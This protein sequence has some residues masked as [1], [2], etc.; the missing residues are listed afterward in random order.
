MPSI[1]EINEELKQA[2]ETFKTKETERKER[3]EAKRKQF[4]ERKTLFVKDAT[5]SIISSF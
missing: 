5:S 4:I 2:L 3:N 1:A